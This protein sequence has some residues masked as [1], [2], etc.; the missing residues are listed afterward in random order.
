DHLLHRVPTGR[1]LSDC[2]ARDEEGGRDERGCGDRVVANRWKPGGSGGRPA[3]AAG[4]GD[5]QDQLQIP[6]PRRARRGRRGRG[7]RRV[8]GRRRCAD[9]R[10]VP[11]TGTTLVAGRER[12]AN[13]RGLKN[14]QIA[15]LALRLT[16]RLMRAIASP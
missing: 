2:P 3:R 1:E 6:L 8:R 5:H 16:L 13:T 15:A 12:T 11:D 4:G 9:L 14:D 10:Y 7:R